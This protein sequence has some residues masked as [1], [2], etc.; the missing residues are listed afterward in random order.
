MNNIT[1]NPDQ[2]RVVDLL[3]NNCK[4]VN[5]FD[6][7][8]LATCRCLRD[9]Q[10]VIDI[11]LTDDE[12]IASYVDAADLDCSEDSYELN[13]FSE[14]VLDNLFKHVASA[15]KYINNLANKGHVEELRDFLK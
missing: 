15:D 14:A 5:L 4:K 10:R 13:K 2:Q 12:A 9:D 3:N 8:G 1:L 6:H 7:N 11:F